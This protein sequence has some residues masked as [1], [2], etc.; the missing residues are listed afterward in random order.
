[1]VTQFADLTVKVSTLLYY[2]LSG[3]GDATDD[4]VTEIRTSMTKKDCIL[5]LL[6]VQAADAWRLCQDPSVLG[7]TW[8]KADFALYSQN[9]VFA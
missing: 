1:M 8:Y 9:C 7:R 3:L 5:L 2:V 6:G 4:N